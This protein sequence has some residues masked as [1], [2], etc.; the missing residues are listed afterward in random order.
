M[1]TTVYAHIEINRK[2]DLKCSTTSSIVLALLNTLRQFNLLFWSMLDKDSKADLATGRDRTSVDNGKARGKVLTRL[3][4]LNLPLCHWS[5]QLFD[6]RVPS[7]TD[8]PVLLLNQPNNPV[9]TTEAT[10]LSFLISSS[11]S[12]ICS[13]A[14]SSK[15]PL[16]FFAS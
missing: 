15:V 10:S 5:S 16:C 8:I 1:K 3:P 4:V 9:E 14:F 12:S 6:L 11:C 2:D 7:S 13:C